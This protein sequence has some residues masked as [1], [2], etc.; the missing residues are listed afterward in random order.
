MESF[1]TKIA[2]L[3]FRE[4][5]LTATLILYNAA[6]KKPAGHSQDLL[7][8][9]ATELHNGIDQITEEYFAKTQRP[10]VE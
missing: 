10:P 4:G 5:L 1:N 6:K 9:I 2:K 8:N 3:A 7:R